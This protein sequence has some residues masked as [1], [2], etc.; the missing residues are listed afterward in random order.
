[1]VD[2]R[3]SISLERVIERPSAMV[4]SIVRLGSFFPVSIS[5]R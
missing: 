1:V 4:L 5:D 3:P 2:Q